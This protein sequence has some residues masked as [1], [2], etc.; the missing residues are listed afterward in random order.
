MATFSAL[1]CA[2][3]E[4]FGV[5]KDVEVHDYARR[6]YESSKH[7]RARPGREQ[8]SPFGTATPSRFATGTV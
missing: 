3:M 1:E 6:G 5:Q 7:Q 4:V 2:Q 8:W